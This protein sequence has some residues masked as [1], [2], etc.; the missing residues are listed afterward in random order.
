MAGLTKRDR[1]CWLV[2]AYAPQGTT[3][4]DAN[5]AWNEYVADTARGPLLF[6]DH[7]A[8]TPG[9]TALFA[10]DTEAELA[11]V[12]D[13]RP[14]ADWDVRI[15]PLIF[16]EGALGF[17]FQCDYTMIGYRKRRLPDLFAKYMASDAGK[18]NAA[19]EL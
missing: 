13:L 6:H 3:M 7:F 14:V 15:H 1:R 9:G 19:R 10:P 16:A 11:A 4:R 12:K 8:D 17:L 5:D 2:N 18:K